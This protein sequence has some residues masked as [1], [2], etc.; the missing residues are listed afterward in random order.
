MTRLKFSRL[1]LAM[2]LLL[3]CIVPAVFAADETI[4]VDADTL[5]LAAETGS[6]VM[7]VYSV[8]NMLTDP[9]E[10]TVYYE[11]TKETGVFSFL[12]PANVDYP[13]GNLTIPPL[14]YMEIPVTFHFDTLQSGEYRGKFQLNSNVTALSVPVKA[15][16]RVPWIVPFILLLFSVL[17]SIVLYNYDLWQKNAKLKKQLLEIRVRIEGDEILAKNTYAQPVKDR[18]ITILDGA[19]SKVENDDLTGAE[20]DRKTIEKLWTRWSG[21][22]SAIQKTLDLSDE[23]AKKVLD[24]ERGFSSLILSPGQA[25]LQIDAQKSTPK[26][27]VFLMEIPK[28]LD[29]CWS[30]IANAGAD[31]PVSFD[32]L[33]KLATNVDRVKGLL[34]KMTKAGIICVQGHDDTKKAEC[35]KKL[36]GFTESLQI[37]S[38]SELNFDEL[39]KQLS[40]LLPDAMKQVHALAAV[41]GTTSKKGAPGLLRES[42]EL[43]PGTEITKINNWIV[44]GN[45]LKSVIVPTIVLTISGFYLLYLQNP[46]FGSLIDYSL[47]VIWGVMSCAATDGIWEKVQAL[48]PT[49]NTAS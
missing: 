11:R 12:E 31:D 20:D 42:Y 44:F 10:V 28:T 25:V 34:E 18:M 40:D 15:S 30:T 43:E 45:W 24:L 37:K 27:F 41:A 19:L 4:Q 48:K 26:T 32:N 9:Q 17:I 36:S 33:T 8:R 46:I 6:N 22:R 5:T 2:L 39:E 7:T 23:I 35:S 29:A 47:L 13:K 49:K 21:N 3:I 14:G 16:L 1:L 38:L